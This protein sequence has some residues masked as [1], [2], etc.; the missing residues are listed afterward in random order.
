MN[1]GNMQ[2]FEQPLNFVRNL[3]RG[4]HVVL[5]YEEVEYARMLLFEFLKSGLMQNKR[6]SYISE[7]GIE[8][9]KREMY[10]AG[11]GTHEFLNNGQ[12]LVHQI[13]NLANHP[14]IPPIE[15]EKLSQ[16]ALHPGT[17]KNGV[18][19]DRLVLKCIFKINTQQQIR[20]NLEWER[21]YRDRDLKRLHGTIICTYPVNDILF[22]I[23]DAIGDYGRWM[24]NLLELYDGVI[25]ARKFWK[26]VAFSLN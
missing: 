25:F 2:F 24:S 16:L 15:L 11:I 13:A 22:T 20:S 17:K 6:C 18:Q 8:M 9:V 23:S 10:D 5:F 1:N 4:K 14:H 7:E 3:G 21:D 19:P 12:L 26:G